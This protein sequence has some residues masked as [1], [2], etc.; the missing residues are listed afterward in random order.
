MDGL[1]GLLRSDNSH[2]LIKS[3]VG[4]YESEF[5]HPFADGNGRIGRFWHSLLLTHYHPIFEFTPVESLI[6]EHQRRYD[7]V[8][9][10]SDRA[11]DGTAFIAFSLEMV[12]Q[13]LDDLVEAIRPECSTA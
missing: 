5:L 6:K 2:A 9:G 13:A 12:H 1:F 3:A 11:G 7:K 8:L 10:T 4:H